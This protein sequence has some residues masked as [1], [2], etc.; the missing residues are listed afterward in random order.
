MQRVSVL[1]SVTLL[2]GA[3]LVAC[4][5]PPAPA[6][7]SPDAGLDAASGPVDAGTD[8]S[9]DGGSDYE[10]LVG[11]CDLRLRACET[12]VAS[13]GCREARDCAF[14]DEDCRRTAALLEPPSTRPLAVDRTVLAACIERV[15]HAAAT[16][17]HASEITQVFTE[18]CAG[19]LVDLAGI[20]ELCA[21]YGR[22][23]AG[24]EGYCDNPTR[25]CTARGAEGET[26]FVQDECR[27]G[28]LCNAARRCVRARADGEACGIIRPCADGLVCAEGS[29]RAPIAAAGAC[30]TTAQCNEGLACIDGTCGEVSAC[31]RWQ[32][33]GELESCHGDQRSICTADVPDGSRCEWDYDCVLPSFCNVEGRCTP[34]ARAGEPCDGPCEDGSFCDAETLR[35]LPYPTARLGEPCLLSGPASI[36]CIEGLCD[37]RTSRCV[38]AV[39]EGGACSPGHCAEGLNCVDGI[40][41][42]PPGL[43]ERCASPIECREGLNCLQETADAVT[44]CVDH[45]AGVGAPCNGSHDC[46]P[47]LYCDYT[48]SSSRTCQPRAA[49]GES[50]RTASCVAGAS[51]TM[52]VPEGGTC[53]SRI[54]PL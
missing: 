29:C 54:C 7:A 12:I 30:V 39:P 3:C 11:W 51:C 46:E 1:V 45:L 21:I 41:T 36:V 53:E 16:C 22:P 9:L 13:C 14:H 47:T 18:P 5:A 40:C 34:P 42:A 15:E 17:Q 35:C 49:L 20:G 23:C 32:D 43:G 37:V 4:D 44:T 24:G 48:S 31:S 19:A 28:L 50:C 10:A 8:A 6:D 52:V 26:C 38:E 27:A 2:A 33:C 25:E